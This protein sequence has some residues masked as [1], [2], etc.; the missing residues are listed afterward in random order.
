VLFLAGTLAF[1]IPYW[2]TLAQ[3]PESLVEMEGVGLV[4]SVIELLNLRPD[5]EEGD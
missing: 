4:D 1:S 2:M 3:L 5:E